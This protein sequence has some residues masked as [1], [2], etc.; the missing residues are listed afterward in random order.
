MTTDQCLCIKMKQFGS[1]YQHF[2]L[3]LWNEYNNPIIRVDFYESY[4][5]LRIRYIM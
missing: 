2:L 5:Y 1:I 3:Y 4:F